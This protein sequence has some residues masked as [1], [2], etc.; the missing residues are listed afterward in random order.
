MSLISCCSCNPLINLIAKEKKLFVISLVFL[1]APLFT[2]FIY[3]QYNPGIIYTISSDAQVSIVK[4]NFDPS[5]IR[6]RVDTDIATDLSTLK[7]YIVNNVGAG[8][9]I[10]IAG[11]LLAVGSLLLLIY[12]GIS[13]GII[14]GYVA[15][16][17]YGETLW[18]FIIGHSSL[19]LLAA[20]FSAVAGLII[21][22]SLIRPQQTSRLKSFAAAFRYALIYMIYATFLY[23]LAGC[24]E[25]FWSSSI[26]IDIAIKYLFGA[27][28]WLAVI[29]IFYS[30]FKKHESR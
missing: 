23:I 5:L 6:F 28:L 10:F 30:V 22:R 16:L 17:G 2:A 21:G 14:I 7:F 15:Q 18:P 1:F 3:A 19:E 27:I 26:H 4:K 9:R 24:I 12:Q 20:T 13:L 25:T 29:Y 11:L 8:L